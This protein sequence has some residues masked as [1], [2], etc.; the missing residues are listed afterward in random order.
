MLAIADRLQIASTE[1]LKR[2]SCRSFPDGLNFIIHYCPFDS[3][4]FSYF[5]HVQNFFVTVII[6]LITSRASD[7]SRRRR[8]SVRLSMRANNRTVLDF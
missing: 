1:G 6:V 7:G 3:D 8:A 4:V 5:S 2:V